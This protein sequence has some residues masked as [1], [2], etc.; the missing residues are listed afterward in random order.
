[1]PDEILGRP[2]VHSPDVEPTRPMHY[3]TYGRPATLGQL[4]EAIRAG[5]VQ[6]VDRHLPSGLVVCCS[7]D[8]FD[9]L[10]RAGKK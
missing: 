8:D 3:G 5:Y 10:T 4:N 1:M 7:A 9:G 2:V 6:L